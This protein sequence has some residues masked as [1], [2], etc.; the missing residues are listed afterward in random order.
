MKKTVRDEKGSKKRAVKKPTVT[1]F[2]ERRRG[3]LQPRRRPDPCCCC[4]P[5]NSWEYKY[6]R[7]KLG[8]AKAWKIVN[9]VKA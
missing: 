6:W 9:L 7:E 1:T 8:L 2:G 4:L 5:W 3:S